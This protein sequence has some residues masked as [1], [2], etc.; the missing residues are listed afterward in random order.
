MYPAVLVSEINSLGYKY[1]TYFDK[2]R[3]HVIPTPT[4]VS[5]S[6]PVV[7]DICRTTPV[8]ETV[9]GATATETTATCQEFQ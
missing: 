1:C 9:D 4:R 7:I 3:V 8:E 6:L 2:R 5:Q